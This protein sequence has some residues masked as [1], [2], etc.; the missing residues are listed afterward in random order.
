MTTEEISLLNDLVDAGNYMIFW[1][2]ENS[3]T[4]KKVTKIIGHNGKLDTAL[5]SV[6][7]VT[8]E[9]VKL[10]DFIMGNRIEPEDFNT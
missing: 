2:D 3:K 5:L 4:A 7:W 9:F 1:W 10:T 8:L 6:G